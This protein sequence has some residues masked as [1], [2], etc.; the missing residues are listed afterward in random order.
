MLV[1]RVE[2]AILRHTLEEPGRLSLDRLGSHLGGNGGHGLEEG[3]W[4]V[5][6][7]LK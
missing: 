1:R 4:N 7:R 2:G 3:L 5:E 6:W